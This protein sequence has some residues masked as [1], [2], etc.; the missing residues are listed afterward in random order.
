LTTINRTNEEK[1]INKIILLGSSF[2]IIIVSLIIGYILISSE[3]KNFKNHLKTF[4]STLFEREKHAIQTTVEN[5]LQD[6]T[7]EKNLNI[8]KVKTNIKNQTTI[9]YNLANALLEQNSFKSKDDIIK[10]IKRSIKSMVKDKKKIS[11]FLLSRDGTLLLNTLSNKNENKNFIYFV[12]IYGKKFI[13]DIIKSASEKNSFVEYTWYKPRSSKIAKKIIYAKM[14]EEL[15]LVIGSGN[16][17]ESNLF[18]SDSMVDKIKHQTLNTD[19]FIFIYELKNLNNPKDLSKLILEKNIETSDKE[20]EVMNQILIDTDYSANSF[21]EYDNK[22]IYSTFLQDIKTFIS[23]GINMSAINKIIENETILSNKNLNKKILS[24]GV[25]IL[26]VVFIFFML[27]YFISRKI[28]IIFKNYRLKVMRNERNYQL[29]FNNSNDAFIISKLHNNKAPIRSSNDVAKKLSGYGNEL[30]GIDFYE[31]ISTLDVEKLTNEREILTRVKLKR[32]DGQMREIE[33]NS[34]IYED[35]DETLLFSSLRDITERINLKKE[36]DKQEQLL[37]QKSKMS[38]MGE[39]IGNI[40]HQW[41]QPLTQLSGL[42]FDIESAYDYKE[43]NKKYLSS[44]IDEANDLVEY[45]SKTIDDFKDFYNPN[46]KK[47]KFRII[48]SVNN[49]L[50]IINS[51]LKYNHIKVIINIDNSLHVEGFA[52]EFSQ[53]IVNILSNSKDIALQREIQNPKIEIFSQVIDENMY[54]HLEDNC[55]GIDV[56]NIEKIFEPYFTTKFNYGTG[57]GLYMSKIIIENKM[58]GKLFANNTKEGKTR[59]TIKLKV[60]NVE[61]T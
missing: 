22:L 14:I 57:I 36:K 48:E 28:E 34:V 19:E 47:D 6:I 40:A 5:L 37:I 56:E 13:K 33:L 7:Y 12:D 59:F 32:K 3:I 21:L 15:D 54:L 60:A 45:M 26:L 55:G 17:L 42:F 35:K 46:T 23:V 43:L 58:N 24:L 39:M 44:R 49:A 38:S 51:S 50:K 2:V 20:L 61:K 52:N 10:I 8:S 30:L 4:K 25:S 18:L 53:V 16:Y 41:R 9:G 11:Y 31:L 27:S 29:L 1:Y